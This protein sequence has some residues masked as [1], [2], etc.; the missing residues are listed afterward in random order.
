MAKRKY[1]TD[2]KVRAVLDVLR[3]RQ[4]ANE[5]ARRYGVHPVQLGEWKRRVL[6]GMP[7]LFVTSNRNAEK[8]E[9]QLK[10]KLYQQIGQL[11]FEL[12]W[13]KKKHRDLG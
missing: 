2:I 4:T 5:I 13:L 7:G 6:Q 8:E 3:E 9:E 10:E 11:Q 1:T 12:E